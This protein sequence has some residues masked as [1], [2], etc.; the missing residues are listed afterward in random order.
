MAT[1][2]AAIKSVLF[3]HT[4]KVTVYVNSKKKVNFEYETHT[5]SH[6]SCVSNDYQ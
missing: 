4:A 6:V 3:I 1:T 5:L 2:I